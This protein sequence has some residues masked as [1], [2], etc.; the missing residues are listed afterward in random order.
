MRLP[1]PPT[2]EID[3]TIPLLF[4]LLDNALFRLELIEYP[5]DVIFGIFKMNLRLRAKSPCRRS[6]I[7][8][9]ARVPATGPVARSFTS[10]LAAIGLRSLAFSE[11]R[12]AALLKK[13]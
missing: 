12:K 6:L 7:M 5:M 10:S 1:L 4:Q 3:L 8:E 13:H 2:A 11:K 9:N